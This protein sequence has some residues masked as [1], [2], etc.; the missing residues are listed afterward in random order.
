VAVSVDQIDAWRQAATETEVL[1]FKEAKKQFDTGKLLEYCVAIGNEGGGHLLLGIHN[2]PPR[3]VVG[4]KA[5]ENP[6]GMAEK[7]FNKLGFRVDIEAVDHPDG[8]VVVLRIPGC[9]PGA[10][11]HLDGSYLMRV[12][13]SLQPMSTDRLRRIFSEGGADWLEEP[14]KT[15]LSLQEVTDLLDLPLAFSL[16]KM[17]QPSLEESLAWMKN[18]WLIEDERGG[19]YRIRRMGALLLAKDLT[20]FPDLKRKAPRVTAYRGATKLTDP[21][22]NKI[23]NRGYAVG[24]TGLVGFVNRL[25]PHKEV[26]AGGLRTNVSIIPEIVVREL[27][28]N[29]LVH[30]DLSISG[31]S[32]AIDVFENRIEISNPGEPI[33]PLDRLIDSARSRNERLADLMRRMGMCEERGSGIDK[34]IDAAES[35]LLPAPAFRATNDRT[36][37]TVYGPRLF[38]DMDR[39][40]RIRAC[41]QH[42]AL[43]WEM[44]E[45]MT[46]QSL[47]GRFNLPENKIY[48]ASQVITSTIEEGLIRPDERAGSS[49]KYARYV[50]F[51]V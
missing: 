7:I 25:I 37:F 14:S 32:V 39:E 1:E 13:E 24:F 44:S 3:P 15:G 5:I 41:Y 45:R 17:P 34:V 40:D 16:L 31:T 19:T 26:I 43:K 36:V 38:D 27:L 51:W 42:C 12:G 2:D 22:E 10:P 33:V 4:T 49:R 8:R 21:I 9:P 50:P 6:V 28:A 11:F 46:N 35:M 30:Q 29:A 48:L 23:G 47:R 20:A 18:E